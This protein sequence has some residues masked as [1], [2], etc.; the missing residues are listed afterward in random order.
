M[1]LRLWL[2]ILGTACMVACRP[3]ANVEQER[4]TLLQQDREWSQTTKDM[5][6]FMSY[7]APD[8]LAYPPGMPLASG[9]ESIRKMF[10][11][12]NSMPGFSLHWTATKADVG[13]AGD[14]GYTTGAY[15]ATMNG[16]TEKGKYV[17]VWK[18][19][20]DGTWKVSND[21]FNADAAPAAKPSQQVMVGTAD[22]KWGDAPPVL[23]A[24]AKAAILAGDPSQ[25]APYVLRLQM[26]AGYKIAPHWHPTDENVTVISGTFALGMGEKFD[27][28][29]MKNLPAGGVAVLP[30]DM[31]HF[32]M[33]T[34]STVVQVHGMG[35]FV[36]T[37]VNPA[38]DPTKQGK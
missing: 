4:S 15:E 28:A 29:A 17:T 34:T 16:A 12:M 22:I 24:G 9:P 21:I 7:Y 14:L 35:P 23:P 3:S 18:K 11:A 33:A 6:K 8:A 13:A 38:D 26:P 5:D 30:A 32:A 36:I 1:R 10:A 19:Q 37:Y 31:R 2:L 25:P 27:Q 20:P